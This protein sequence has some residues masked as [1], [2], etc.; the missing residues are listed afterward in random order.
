M[1]LYFGS[2]SEFVTDTIQHRLAEKLG[3]AYYEYFHRKVSPAEFNAWRN[4]LTALTAHIQFARLLDHGIILELQ[5]PLS[6]SRLDVLLTGLDNERRQN[7]VIIE[8]KQWSSVTRSD[9]EAC[10]RTFVGKA[11]RDV[12]H[13]SAQVDRYRQYLAD[14]NSAFFDKIDPITL[15]AC[16]WLHNLAGTSRAILDSSEFGAVLAEAPLFAAHDSDKFTKYLWARLAGGKGRPIIDKIAQGRFQPSKGL[17]SHASAVIRGDPIYTLLDD[18]V[19]AYN[20]VLGMARAQPRKGEHAVAVIKGGPGTG[21]SLIALNVMAQLLKE[22]RNVQHATGSRAFTGSLRKRL[23]TR[24]SALLK[25]FN[26]YSTADPGVVDVLVMDEAHRIR[27]SSNNRFTRKGTRSDRSQIQELIE[28]ARVSVFFLDDFQIVRPGEIGSTALIRETAAALGARYREAELETQFRCAGSDQYV[29]WLD[30]LL[31]IRKTGITELRLDQGFDFQIIDDPTELDHL[32]MRKA[33]EGHSARL[34]AGFCWPWS[35]PRADG[36]LI[37]DVQIGEFRR[38][39]NAKPE[40]TKLA[41]GIP[42]AN[43]WAADPNGIAQVGCIYT[44]QGF[45]FDYVGV[46]FG[47]DLRYDLTRNEWI[48]TPAESHDPIRRQSG[49]RF[50]DFARSAYRVLLTRGMRGCYVHFVDEHTRNYVASH[51]RGDNA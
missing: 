6:S 47:R 5:L 31:D 9:I 40:A 33:A 8:L 37:D 20:M 16:S 13:P 24:A 50:V 21:K 43:I 41:K 48:G 39:W 17:M 35:M 28:A 26:S 29:A 11:E 36:T 30:E 3:D 23:G 12:L 45:E 49:G 19:V 22:G 4:S 10:V 51:I 46:I 38:P 15:T 34:T 2:T 18:Q 27:T 44:A 32:I 1:Q 25:Y 42:K 7:A 14:M